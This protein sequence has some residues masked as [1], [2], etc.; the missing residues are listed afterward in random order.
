MTLLIDELFNGIVFEQKFKIQRHISLAHFRPWMYK[1]GN[2]LTGN[3]TCEVWQDAT[4]LKQVQI[5]YTTIN[6]EIPGTYAHGQ[7][8]FDMDALQ[9][10]HNTL[11]EWTEYKVKVYMSNYTNSSQHFIGTVRR[12]ELKFYDTYGTGVI[13][14]EAPND[15]VEPLGF[16]LFEYKYR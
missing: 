2:L 15:M 4:M 11:N 10:N 12:Y 9:L 1:H 8:R 6:T 5:P 16:E 3:L 13:A 14:N 7:I